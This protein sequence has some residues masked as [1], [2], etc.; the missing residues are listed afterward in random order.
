MFLGKFS[1]LFV[2]ALQ[3][4]SE[5]FTQSLQTCLNPN[6]NLNSRKNSRK[7]TLRHGP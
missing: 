7:G 5:I 6:P 4:L 3:S 2:K 1:R